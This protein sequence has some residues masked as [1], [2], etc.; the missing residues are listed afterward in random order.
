MEK[1]PEAELGPEIQ[2][3]GEP[4]KNLIESFD[5][6]YYTQGTVTHRSRFART[7]EDAKGKER[8][9]FIR[10]QRAELYKQ[11]LALP[12]NTEQ[13]KENSRAKR[14]VI[15]E[16]GH[17]R[18]EIN[19]QYFKQREIA[20]NLPRYGEQ[21]SRVVDIHPP[22]ELQTPE[23]EAKPPIFLIPGI[24]NDI[25]CVSSFI[26]EV[27]F[28]GRRIVTVGYPESFMGHTT[29]EFADAVEKD[30]GFAPHIEFYKAVI[31]KLF[32]K[33][34][35]IELWGFSTGAP[36]ISGIL[37]DK[38]YSQMTKDAA[39]ILP[40]AVVDQSL[41][42]LKMGVVQELGLLKGNSTASLNLTVASKVPK[43]KEQTKLREEV[44]E[45]LLNKICVNNNDWRDARVR[46][47]GN[48]IVV[49][50]GKDKITKGT[51]MNEEFK[52]GNG[53]MRVVDIPD[54]YH[55][56]VQIDPESV[57][58]KLFATEREMEENLT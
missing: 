6:L 32:N 38:K 11:I 31:D 58:S 54:A 26:A 36:I 3:E 19:E 53:Q 33:G 40:A 46:E 48:I 16:E 23:T 56:T 50:G 43:E 8:P 44:L 52:T 30:P 42:S 34:E 28:Q 2:G 49:T 7:P 25:E 27:A 39:L 20:I 17:L 41:N 13:E 37:K 21:K 10:A 1:P 29:Q 24:S 14:K 22:E 47:G 18:D 12:H 5:K 45:S 15:I 4:V 55:S 51:M 57:V 9:L 35:L